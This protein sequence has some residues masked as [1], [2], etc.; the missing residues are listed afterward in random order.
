MYLET[1]VDPSAPRTF[2]TK[3]GAS[4]LKESFLALSY[5]KCLTKSMEDLRAA[6]QSL[7]A[8]LGNV[9]SRFGYQG[10]RTRL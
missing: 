1:R 3:K 4:L 2:P 9:N 6:F 7:E 10:T 8:G 5:L